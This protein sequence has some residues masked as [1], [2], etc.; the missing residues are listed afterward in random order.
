VL[1]CAGDAVKGI[2]RVTNLTDQAE[3]GFV[4]PLREA[5][6]HFARRDARS[7]ETEM[8]SSDY[9]NAHAIRRLRSN[10]VSPTSL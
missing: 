4:L 10:R 1:G 6:A 8:G 7:A 5:F 3:S 9:G 2:I